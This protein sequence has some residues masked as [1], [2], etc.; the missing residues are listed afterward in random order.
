MK[1]EAR[2][3]GIGGRGFSR[4]SGRSAHRGRLERS[5]DEGTEMMG[6]PAAPFKDEHN[7]DRLHPLNWK[8]DRTFKSS[9]TAIGSRVLYAGSGGPD[10][11]GGHQGHGC[12]P[13]L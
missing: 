9:D 13:R 8:A 10:M 7:R 4:P 1:I 11:K 2:C 12:R 3:C 6:I 5:V